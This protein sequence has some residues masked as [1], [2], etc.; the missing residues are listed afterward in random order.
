MIFFIFLH[1][2][3]ILLYI[4]RLIDDILEEMT[5]HLFN[6]EHDIALAAHLAHFTAPHAARQL[7]ADLCWLPALWAGADDAVL[8]ENAS[9]ARKACSRLYKKLGHLVPLFVEREQLPQLDITAVDP[10]GWDAALAT[11]LQRWGVSADVMPDTTQLE[12]YRQLSHRRTSAQLLPSLRIEGTVGEAVECASLE[13]VEDCMERWGQIVVK[14]PWSSSGRGVHFSL[15][16]GWIN[17]IIKQQGCVMVEP[18]YNKVKDF[19]MEFER[20]ASGQIQYLGLSLFHTKNG[21]YIGNLLATE[22]AKREEMGRYVSLELLDEIK[23]HIIDHAQ[24]GDYQGPFGIDM[25]IVK[26][27]VHPCVELNLRR[28]MGHVA[29]SMN[30]TDDD[31]R[32]VMRIELND[33]YKLRVT[34]LARSQQT[35]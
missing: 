17:N 1:I 11:D 10:W 4:C 22:E 32:R 20:D 34:S 8:V 26:E 13:Q 30:P 24:L 9:Y 33:H 35:L 19:G 18:Y 5:L 21:A 28:T 16:K 27:G 31:V 29:L 2:H 12:R 6:P 15:Q 7:K 25:M 3:T 23:Q 14:S